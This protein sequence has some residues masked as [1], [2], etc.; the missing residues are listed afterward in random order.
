LK[1]HP[2]FVGVQFHPEFTSRLT[3]P[4]PIIYSFINSAYL[5]KNG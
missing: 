1:D 2:W 3:T 4:N 5:L